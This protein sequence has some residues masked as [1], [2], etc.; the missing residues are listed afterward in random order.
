MPNHLMG[1]DN[2]L[3][4]NDQNLWSIST[5]NFDIE[6]ETKKKTENFDQDN[7]NNTTTK[8][9][10]NN[11]IDTVYSIFERLG[12]FLHINLLL[13]KYTVILSILS[14]LA[15]LLL[16]VSL[17]LYLFSNKTFLYDLKS[18]ESNTTFNNTLWNNNS[19][20]IIET[21]DSTKTIKQSYLTLQILVIFVFFICFILSY[22]IKLQF[23]YHHWAISLYDYN[24]GAVN[25][26]QH[27]QIDRDGADSLASTTTAS[28]FSSSKNK[29]LKSLIKR[30]LN[31]LFTK[32]ASIMLNC[33]YGYQFCQNC[34]IEEP[35]QLVQE[36]YNIFV[37]FF[38]LFSVLVRCLIY[39]CHKKNSMNYINNLKKLQDKALYDPKSTLN[40]NYYFNYYTYLIKYSQKHYNQLKQH[41]NNQNTFRIFQ[42]DDL[43]LFIGY[44]L[45][46]FHL[47]KFAKSIE[48]LFLF[49]PLLLTLILFRVKSILSA[50]INLTCVLLSIVLISNWNSFNSIQQIGSYIIQNK[51]DFGFIRSVNFD[52]SNQTSIINILSYNILTFA[53]FLLTFYFKSSISI[54]YCSLN[55]LERWNI[56]FL[57]RLNIWRKL[58]IYT[59]F[60]IYILF[61]L[62]CAITLCI[63]F[64]KWSFLI[65]PLFLL[66]ALV[67]SSFQLLHIINL[68]HLM[69]KITDCFLLLNEATSTNSFENSSNISKKSKNFNR[70]STLTQSSSSNNN[71][72]SNNN[73][74]S[75]KFSKYISRFLNYD[76][77]NF[78]NVYDS[79]NNINVP[80]HRIL[81]YKGVRHLGSISYRICLYCFA[82]TLLLAPFAYNTN[83]PLTIGLYLITLS[84]NFI[85]LSLLYLFPKSATGTCIAYALVAPPLILNIY[86]A[87][88]LSSNPTLTS[89][90]TKT[91]SSSGSSYY[92]TSSSSGTTN[93]NSL[94]YLPF[95]YQQALTQRCN[96][97]VNK[98]QTFLQFYLIENFGCDYAQTGLNKETLVMKIKTYFSK[99]SNDGAYYNTY[100][101]YYCGP[102]STLTDSLSF[103]DGNELSIEEIIDFWKEIHCGE[104]DTS[105]KKSRLILVLDAENTTKSLQF[106]KSKINDPNVYVALQTVK[107]NYNSS[108]FAKNSK[109][110]ETKL[111]LNEKKHKIKTMAPGSPQV[112]SENFFDSYLNIGKFTLDWI[113]SNCNSFNTPNEDVDNLNRIEDYVLHNEFDEEREILN[114]GESG[115][116][117]E[118]GEDEDE[119]NEEYDEDDDSINYENNK[120]TKKK[121][122]LNSSSSFFYEAKCAFSRFWHEYTFESSESTLANDLSQFWKMYYPYVV[123]RPILNLINCR[124]FYIK[125][126]FIKKILFYLRRLKNKII[127]V[128]EY[129]TGHGFKLFNS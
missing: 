77:L 94:M 52:Y 19:D 106:V 64:K 2:E 44:L 61:V 37:H 113:K 105:S 110:S 128:H 108:K 49:A 17:N 63:R 41:Q 28:Q 76:R 31:R 126:N 103:I 73:N 25:Q 62:S 87:G 118:E 82:Q 50:T 66:M 72:N 69:N 84:I 75:N 99:R 115:E 21:S 127:R 117:E 8:T 83:S 91:N 11:A 124:L 112:I 88:T 96:Y 100:I 89:K 125:L 3:I 107:Y 123:C 13:N 32:I 15:D 122:H 79:S 40:K 71:N 18:F 24:I 14:Y 29:K 57:C 10:S 98:I 43:F 85:W 93:I 20:V 90:K 23:K 45:G 65:L 39:L 120:D 55:S 26:Q 46:L 92:T 12:H 47:F 114:D 129:D 80:I 33:M 95:N 36:K 104:E 116:E 4:N 51:T 68:S 53:G 34:F 38:I 16:F 7:L 48:L 121:K 59:S 102:T 60:L 86:N 54:Y 9:Q 70:D 27:Q 78:N 56:S 67:W 30:L 81:G 6:N 58:T 42:L 35:R 101:F 1:T 74:K 111:I 119:E 97:I 109:C 5:A 22:L